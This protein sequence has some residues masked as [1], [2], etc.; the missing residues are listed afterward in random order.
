MKYVLH[1]CEIVNAAAR[2]LL[3]STVCTWWPFCIRS[4]SLRHTFYLPIDLNLSL[5]LFTRSFLQCVQGSFDLTVNCFD[6]YIGFGRFST[7]IFLAIIYRF[8]SIT[9][10]Y[11]FHVC[12]LKRTNIAW[13][14]KQSDHQIVC[15]IKIDS[16]HIRVD[17]CQKLAY[18]WHP[19][20]QNIHIYSTLR[21][22]MLFN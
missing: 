9:H 10:P 13:N 17:W 6:W 18:H 22:V 12:P 20:N 14:S 4:I 19:S 11:N 3:K 15:S 7:S 2:K 1:S 16:R 5:S 8:F 21:A